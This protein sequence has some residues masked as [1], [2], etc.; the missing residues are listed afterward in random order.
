MALGFE[1]AVSLVVA[2][3][4]AAVGVGFLH[5]EFVAQQGGEP[6]N[7]SGRRPELISAW[8]SVVR[9]SVPLKRGS[10]PVLIAEFGDYE[11]PACRDFAEVLDDVALQLGDTVSVAFVHYPL[12]RHRFARPAA[13]AAECAARFELFSSFHKLLYQKQDSLGLKSWASFATETGFR[14]TSAFNTC[15]KEA[16]EPPR[17]RGGVEQGKRLAI[18]GTPTI[19]INGWRF[20]APPSR[21]EIL[22]VSRAIA[23][24]VS[25]FPHGTRT[26]NA[27]RPGDF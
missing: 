16:E 2:L 25:P 9:V 11:C 20:L 17:I 5:R 7:S 10:G 14:D 19:V 18:E 24:G 4:A 13:R 15:L 23:R 21:A 8:D 6:A 27:P 12:S 3:S 1:K 22:R 26:A